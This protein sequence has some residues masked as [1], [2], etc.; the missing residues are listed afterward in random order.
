MTRKLRHPPQSGFTL[1]ELLV[2]LVLVAFI[3]T[4][5]I[6]GM[7]YLAKVNDSF[8]RQGD[9][10]QA[11]E[12]AFGWFD[13]AL[14]QLTAPAPGDVSAGFR[15]DASS[16]EG[17]T[18]ASVDRRE[19]IPIPFAFRLEPD[20][21]GTRLIYVRRIE[22]RRWPLILLTGETHFEYL[23]AAGQWHKDWPPTPAQADLLPAAVALAGND[24]RSF[25][26][27]TVQ[28]PQ[29]QVIGNDF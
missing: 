17:V 20:D 6:Q 27:A 16:F 25:L 19:G 13:D 24:G 15:G 11:R 22:A 23:D 2:V 12:L 8:V 21:G 29:R 28:T 18:S 14:S 5:L 1:L 4:L 26:M 10:H 7:G 3:T 9:Q